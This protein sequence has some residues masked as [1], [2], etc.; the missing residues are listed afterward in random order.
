MLKTIKNFGASLLRFIRNSILF[1]LIIVLLVFFFGV[2]KWFDRK[3]NVREI[4]GGISG[5]SQKAQRLHE[6]LVIADWHSD[7]LLWDRDVLDRHSHG[8][9][10]VPRLV[11]G[12][13]SLQVFDAV[14]KTPRGLNYI[15]N[16]DKTDNV[17]LLSMANRWPIGT[18]FNLT[19]R[20]LH[21]SDIIH[22]AANKS[23]ALTI[24]RTR[25][26]LDV[27]MKI[28]KSNSSMVGG[29][30]SIEGLH[31][32]E[33]DIEN[34]DRLIDGGYRIMGLVHFFDNEVGGSSAGINQGGLTPLGRKVIRK[35]NEQS[36]IID[37][38][39]SSPKLMED[40]LALSTKPVIV[41]HTGV[42][43]SFES[44]RNLS[45]DQLKSITSKGGMIGIGFWEGAVGDTSL[46]SIVDAIRHTVS[47]AGI[48]H[49][50]LG[51][52][53]DGA[54]TVLFD[55]SQIILLTESLMEA[56]FSDEE[57]RKIMGGNQ[58]KFLFENLP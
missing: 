23:S 13:Y 19:K 48:D 32:L 54:T 1:L 3:M 21:Q 50:S 56:G 44:P 51:S 33:G 42:K 31:A 9:V 57:I 14:I 37:L 2:G 40:V 41:S 43:G 16:D 36:I 17:T 49:V 7:N 18:W 35:M 55:A 28:R 5:V 12:N 47:V 26:D 6:S 8:H 10:D 29:L 39:H 45:D 15:S 52:D 4:E 30:L 24:I 53:F 34:L 22:Q 27:F 38:A 20:A 25:S 58:V 46:E 11:E